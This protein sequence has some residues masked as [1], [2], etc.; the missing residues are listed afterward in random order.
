M[1]IET[2]T[3]TIFRRARCSFRL[4]HKNHPPRRSMVGVSNLMDQMFL[5]YVNKYIVI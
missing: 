5:W 2:L 1:R 4:F 3:E